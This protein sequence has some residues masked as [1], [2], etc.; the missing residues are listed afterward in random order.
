MKIPCRDCG[1]MQNRNRKV[2]T[3]CWECQKENQR[4]KKQKDKIK[5]E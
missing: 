5:H 3:V 2:E 1:E 4:I